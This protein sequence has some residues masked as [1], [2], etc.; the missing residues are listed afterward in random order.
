MPATS[1]AE[2]SIDGAASP[3]VPIVA[4]KTILVFDDEVLL[5]QALAQILEGHRSRVET[6]GD[7]EHATA[8]FAPGRFDAVLGGLRRPGMDGWPVAA[9]PRESHPG[10]PVIILTGHIAIND[11]AL[12]PPGVVAILS[13][14][15]TTDQLLTAIGEATAG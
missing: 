4:G 8:R 6:A 3:E 5:R 7:G 12:D 1:P 2:R 15:G 9:R 13:K 11:K 14:P 10:C